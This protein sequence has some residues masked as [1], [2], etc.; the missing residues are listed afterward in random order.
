MAPTTTSGSTVSSSDSDSGC[1]N[2]SPGANVGGPTY[3][4]VVVEVE[5]V[6]VDVV[7][8]DVGIDVVGGVA[9]FDDPQPRKVV[10]VTTMTSVIARDVRSGDIRSV[11]QMFRSCNVRPNGGGGT[12]G[13]G[14]AGGDADTSDA[15]TG[16][17]NAGCVAFENALDMGD[18]LEMTRSILGE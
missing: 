6:D 13:L 2:D 4:V 12:L 7:D 15:G 18:S 9:S 1:G 17:A 14:D 8:V 5:V 16:Q 3:T 10:D 11:S